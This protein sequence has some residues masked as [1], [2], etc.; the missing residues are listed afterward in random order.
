MLLITLRIDILEIATS[1]RSGRQRSAFY[2]VAHFTGSTPSINIAILGL[3]P[4]AL[5]CRPLRGLGVRVY[6]FAS[7]VRLINSANAS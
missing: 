2:A 1:P 7:P 5:F 4:Q 6:G 3:A